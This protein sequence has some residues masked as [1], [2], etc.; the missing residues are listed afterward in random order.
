[1]QLLAIWISMIG[2][3]WWLLIMF[4]SNLH[5]FM[6]ATS[7]QFSLFP[8]FDY[9]YNIH[10]LY[11]KFSTYTCFDLWPYQIANTYV[12]MYVA[13][14][15][16]AE[17][18]NESNEMKRSPFCIQFTSTHQYLFIS[19][20]FQFIFHFVVCIL[21]KS[22]LLQIWNMKYDRF[23]VVV[24]VVYFCFSSFSLYFVM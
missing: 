10:T 19:L 5:F 18:N 8:S 24:V 14:W 2:H 7:K 21:W 1:M 16:F 17:M 4:F 6:D 12:N 11:S 9:I 23:F 3:H 15:L 22:H 20:I 13:P